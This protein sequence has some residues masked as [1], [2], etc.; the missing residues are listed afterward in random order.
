MKFLLV[1]YQYLL[2]DDE[3]VRTNACF[4]MGV[5][6]IVA[7]QQLLGQ[8]E[9]ILNRLSQVLIKETNI[10]MIDNICSCLCRMIVVSTTHVPLGQVEFLRN[11]SF[12]MFYNCM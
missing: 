6:C 9:T 12:S 3:E 1:F 8:Y 10:R 4:G 5:L 2:D 7:N 11:V